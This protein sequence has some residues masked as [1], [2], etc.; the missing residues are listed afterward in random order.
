MANMSK[1]LTYSEAKQIGRKNVFEIERCHQN[2][3]GEGIYLIQFE[4]G[5]KIGRSNRLCERMVAYR[6]PWMQIA[7]EAAFYRTK[8]SVVLEN[9][10]QTY[11]KEALKGSTEFVQGG[12]TLATLVDFV[13]GRCYFY[14][15]DEPKLKLFDYGSNKRPR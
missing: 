3:S 14:P 8:N 9:E 11:Y 4:R 5:I 10:I 1:H 6:S 12:V 2:Y 15:N 7:Y 13:E